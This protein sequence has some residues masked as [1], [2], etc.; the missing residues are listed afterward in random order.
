MKLSVGKLFDHLG[1]THF[2][3]VTPHHKIQDT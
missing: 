1:I 2:T 3:Q